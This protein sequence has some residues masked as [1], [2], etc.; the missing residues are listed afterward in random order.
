M[1]DGEGAIGMAAMDRLDHV[2]N[3]MLI[4]GSHVF[5]GQ[6]SGTCLNE[7]AVVAVGFPDRPVQTLDDRPGCFSR[8][9]CRLAM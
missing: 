6:D 4:Q 1:I 8:P 7:A 5:P 3:R 9:I 2:L